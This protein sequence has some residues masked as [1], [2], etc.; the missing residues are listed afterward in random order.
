[1]QGK[2]GS[3][4]AFSAVGALEGAYALAH[5]KLVDLSVQNIVDCSGM[6]IFTKQII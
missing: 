6:E 5:D 1:M 2:C 4:Y 3:C